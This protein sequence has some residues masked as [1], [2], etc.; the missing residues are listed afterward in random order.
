MIWKEYLDKIQKSTRNDKK[1]M[2]RYNDKLIHFGDVNYEHFYDQT[3]IWKK[4]DHNDMQRRISYRKRHEA[5]KN[6]NGKAAYKDAN[7][8]AYWSYHILWT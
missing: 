2:V 1:L 4:L 7:H 6:K 8:G 3:R 5:I